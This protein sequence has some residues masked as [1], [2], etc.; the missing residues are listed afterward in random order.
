MLAEDYWLAH[1]EAEVRVRASFHQGYGGQ[2]P[3]LEAAI[4]ALH[5]QVTTSPLSDESGPA[6]GQ[7]LMQESCLDLA[8]CYLNP[9][10]S[11]QPLLLLS[12][13]TVLLYKMLFLFLAPRLATSAA[14]STQGVPDDSS[15]TLTAAVVVAHSQL[16]VCCLLR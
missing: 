13:T 15:A 11:D 4:R 5:A 14:C 1:P 8:C 9:A 12:Q 2:L 7:G 3:E 16:D 10:P 6:P